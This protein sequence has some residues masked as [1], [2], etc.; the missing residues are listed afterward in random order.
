[1][2]KNDEKYKDWNYNQKI[3]VKKRLYLRL[4]RIEILNI[5]GQGVGI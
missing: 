1:M 2:R 5:K 4:A 3:I